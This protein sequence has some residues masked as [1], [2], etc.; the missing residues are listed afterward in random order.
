MGYI[1]TPVSQFV[2]PNLHHCVTGVWTDTAGSVAGTIAK[3]KT[4]TAET[5]I[6]NIPILLPSSINSAY[7]KGAYLTS[8]EVDYEVTVAALT[9]LTA[10]LSKI[11]RGADTVGLTV[12]TPVVTQDLVAATTAATVA[13]HKMIIALTTP[14]WISN[15]EYCLLKLTSIAPATTVVDLLGAIANFT[16]KL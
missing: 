4:A 16:L 12:T 5:S 3:R 1:N 15:L 8:I 10:A 13:K 7:A 11:S 6:V 9:S 14:I 2:P